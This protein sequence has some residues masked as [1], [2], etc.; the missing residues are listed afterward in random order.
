MSL[1]G[2]IGTLG[3]IV[4]ALLI[5]DPVVAGTTI[6]YLGLVA[7]LLAKVI[8]PLAVRSGRENRLWSQK[9][10]RL[11][12]EALGAL[13][14][15]TLAGR[16][17]DVK[18]QVHETRIHSSSARAQ[19]SFF[20]QVPRYVLEAALVL[21]FALV[22]GVGYLTGGSEG[23]VAATGMFA[24]AGFR[25]VPSLTRFQAVQSQ[26]NSSASFA[27][28]VVDDIVVGERHLAQRRAE[29][30][31][32]DLRS[33]HPDIEL[34]SI[35]FEYP[36][37]SEPAV[38]DVSLRIP[39]GSHVAFVGSSGAGKSTMVDLLLGLLEPTSG[40]ILVGGEDMTLVLDSWR[41]HIGYVPQDVSLFD[42][43]V[44]ENVA[45][46]WNPARVDRQRA[47]EALERAQLWDVIE[48]REGGLD[49]LV[50]ERGMALSGGQRQRLG[51][52]RAL[53][54]QP[55]VLVMDEATS[56]LDT[57]T[58]A[59]VTQ[60]VRSLHGKVTV[61]TVAHR[62]ATIRDSDVVFFLRDGRLAAHGRFDE[63]VS[64]VPDFAEQ[65]ALAGL[66]ARGENR[67]S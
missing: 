67:I 26:V 25:L 62:L 33:P 47:R 54:N 8:S 24:I 64:A 50:G 11:L 48:A 37:S 66:T 51:I 30:P 34:Q 35:V 49:A 5:F 23:A 20:G 14:E 10:V 61:I 17:G 65:A 22:G 60:A 32:H 36:T 55:R 6:V 39:S 7:V 53:Y 21:G 1:F 4:V 57:T 29:R 41:S 15:V 42:A 28:A 46:T 18:E 27:R 9:T 16:I 63:V 43:T 58:E 31:Q 13:K 56:A 59:L 38:N 3:A 52:A 45:L 12:S 44:G 2:E 40:T 19:A